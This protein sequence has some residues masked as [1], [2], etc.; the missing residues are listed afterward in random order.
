[1]RGFT[2]LLS[3]VGLAAGYSVLETVVQETEMVGGRLVEKME[4]VVEDELF[5]APAELVGERLH[6]G[7]P[8]FHSFMAIH[9]KNY[10]SQQ[11]YK[12]RYRIFRQNMKK[13]AQ[14]QSM[15]RGSAI[16]G[17]NIN[18]DDHSTSYH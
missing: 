13:V 9:N 12:R 15:E 7:L 17:V 3:L 14:L 8:A 10:S 4:T 11:E 2:A 16:Y 1:M 6:A 18:D 5:G